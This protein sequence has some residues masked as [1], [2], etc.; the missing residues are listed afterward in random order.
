MAE[1]AETNPLP[2]LQSQE[3]MW[4]EIG[5]HK[6]LAGFWYKVILT[7]I[8]L[9]IG[10]FLLNSFI[11]SFPRGPKPKDMEITSQIYLRFI[12]L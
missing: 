3:E 11:I 1:S 8:G 5:F 12:S 6:P 7:I 9:F 10:V 2:S 4:N